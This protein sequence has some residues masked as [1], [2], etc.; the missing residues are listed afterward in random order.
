FPL[1]WFNTTP[2]LKTYFDEVL[3]YG[4][5]Y[6]SKAS[7]LIGKP[8][9]LCI[10]TGASEDDFKDSSVFAYPFSDYIKPYE[11]IFTYIKG[12]FIGTHVFYGAGHNADHSKNGG[13]LEAD[14]PKF[15]SFYEKVV[16]YK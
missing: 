2:L 7:K 11:S 4:Y 5:A 1:Y 13:S 12:V 3:T 8:F 9:G 16:N 15:N 6:G 10:S 14:I